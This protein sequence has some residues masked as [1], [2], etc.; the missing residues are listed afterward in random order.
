MNLLSINLEL[1]GKSAKARGLDGTFRESWFEQLRFLDPN[2]NVVSELE[3]D[4][5]L[6]IQQFLRYVGIEAGRV[7]KRLGA[8]SI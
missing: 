3:D 5:K 7:S 2:D 1:V 8:N 6:A 4:N